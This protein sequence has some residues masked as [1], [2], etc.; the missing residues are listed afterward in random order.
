[1]ELIYE[2]LFEFI[3]EGSIEICKNKK[4]NS[5]IRVG[6]FLTLFIFF[7]SFFIIFTLVTIQCLKNNILGGIF[8]LLIELVLFTLCIR[9]FIKE[10]TKV[11]KRG[12][13][14]ETRRNK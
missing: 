14:N 8:V 5:I 11:K 10:L 4:I 7:S 2:I 9:R 12:Y 6:A 13:L 1:M 3:L